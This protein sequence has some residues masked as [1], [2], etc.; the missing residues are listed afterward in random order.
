[1]VA[2][3]HPSTMSTSVSLDVFFFFQAEDGIRD[4]SVTGVQTCALPISEHALGW[5][6]VVED[7][8]RRR[9]E[10]LRGAV[11]PIELDENS[12]GLLRATPPHGR[13]GSF[14]V[15]AADIGCD[16]D[17]GFQAHSHVSFVVP[18]HARR[19]VFTTRAA[20]TRAFALHRPR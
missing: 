13:E 2:R 5:P 15:A 14:D 20:A 19:P 16:P 9:P 11:E 7:A 6:R 10:Q 3:R 1:L 18:A 17:C 4:W 12:P 8:L